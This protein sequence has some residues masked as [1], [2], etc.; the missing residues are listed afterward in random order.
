MV[1]ENWN[2]VWMQRVWMRI[3]MKS[4]IE[5]HS[6]WMGL[7]TGVERVSWCDRMTIEIGLL[8]SPLRENSAG[9]RASYRLSV[10]LACGGGLR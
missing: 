1:W 4:G 7:R 5:E 2:L 10:F 9:R 3:R 6:S 8:L